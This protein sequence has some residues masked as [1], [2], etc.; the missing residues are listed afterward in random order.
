MCDLSEYA[1]PPFFYLLSVGVVTT[2]ILSNRNTSIQGLSTDLTD[3]DDDGV[4]DIT[5][6]AY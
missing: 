6:I 5:N 2:D 4:D 3:D 1:Q